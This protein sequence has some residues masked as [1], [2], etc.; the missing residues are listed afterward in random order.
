M[1]SA[2][3]HIPRPFEQVAGAIYEAIPETQ[4]LIKKALFEF[5]ISHNE[6]D[7]EFEAR[8]LPWL[9]LKEWLMD[10]IP[11]STNLTDWQFEVAGIFNNTID[12]KKYH[13]NPVLR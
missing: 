8:E 11:P 6:K 12:Y 10:N 13:N 7:K 2:P 3:E 4:V 1:K 9:L 5:I